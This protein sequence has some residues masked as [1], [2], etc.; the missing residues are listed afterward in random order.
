M[1]GGY[2][3]I[4]QLRELSLK[5]GKLLRMSSFI[6]RSQGFKCAKH[7]PFPLCTRRE[8]TGEYPKFSLRNNSSMALNQLCGLSHF[9]H[10]QFFATPWSHVAH[11]APLSMG[12]FWQEYWS[13]LPC[14]QNIYIFADYVLVPI[15]PT[16]ILG[17]CVLFFSQINVKN[18][19][20]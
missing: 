20:Q 8:E 15:S 10:V 4:L 7:M 12:F 19:E 5:R 3:S 9:S 1:R 14:P 16:K 17:I 6:S 18:L 2:Y 13:G 11:Q